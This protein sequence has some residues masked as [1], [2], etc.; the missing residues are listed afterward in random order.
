MQNCSKRS[1][2][3]F[4]QKKQIFTSMTKTDVL[5]TT[6]YFPVVL[7]LLYSLGV[8]PNSLLNARLK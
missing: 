6:C 5:Y 3:F 1:A 4:T 7:S 8:R 2:I